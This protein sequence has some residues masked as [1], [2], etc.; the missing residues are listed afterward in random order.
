MPGFLLHLPGHA[1]PGGIQVPPGHLQLPPHLF[2][3]PSQVP[4]GLPKLPVLRAGLL[5]CAAE[6]VELGL[7]LQEV[8]GDG[9]RSPVALR[10][11]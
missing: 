6:T 10:G 2:Q 11:D 1:A 5:V 4:L 3:P 7:Q 9:E 8:A